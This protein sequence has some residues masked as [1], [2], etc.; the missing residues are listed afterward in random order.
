MLHWDSAISSRDGK[1]WA[2]SPVRC[3][4]ADAM[5]AIPLSPMASLRDRSMDANNTEEANAR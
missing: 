4:A 1:A 5:H 3:F 2:P